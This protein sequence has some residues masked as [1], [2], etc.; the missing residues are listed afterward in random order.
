MKKNLLT[1]LLLGFFAFSGAFAQ[2][3]KTT[4]KVIG[5]DDGLPLPGVTVKVKGTQTGVQTDGDGKFSIDA[6]VGAQLVFSYIGFTEQTIAVPAG[7][8]PVVKLVTNTRLLSEVVVTDGY[9][10]QARKSYT[11]SATTISGAANENKPFSSPMQALQG[12]VA[13]LNVQTNSGQPGANVQVRLR[14]VNSISAGANPLYVIDNMIVNSGDLSRLTVTTNVLAGINENDIESITVL[15]DAAATAIYG[16]RGG[17][18]VIV[19]TTKKGKAGKTQIRVDAE[20][21]ATSNLNPPTAGRLLTADE[22]KTLFTEGENNAAVDFP[23]TFTPTRVASDI[24]SYIGTTSNDWYKLIT[25]TGTQQQYN[26]SM[27]GGSDATRVFGS[28]GYFKQEA[29]TIASSLKRITG[30]FNVDHNISKRFTISTNINFSNVNQFTPSNGGAFANPVGSIY[31]LTPF[32]LAYNPD[33]TLNSSRA[34][35]TNFPSQFN[36]LYLAKNDKKYDSQTRILTGAT[37]KWNIWD[38]LKFTSF[39]SID[40]NVLEEQQFNNPIMGDGRTSNGRGYDYYTRYFNWL[41]RNSLD[42]RYDIPGI[43]NFYVSA[44]VGYEAQ[45]SQ[46]YFISANS[47]GY[48]ATQPLLT[49]SANA[50]T[51][52]L[53]NSSF[54]NYAVDALYSVAS[55]NYKNR[56][57]LSGSFR[58][59]GSSVFGATNKYGNFASIGGAWNIDQ[60]KFFAVQKVLSSAK[61]RSSF[62]TTGNLSGVG[63]YSAQP[64]AGYGVNY[65]G[66]NGQNYSTVGNPDLA[67]E[68]QKKFDV[69]MD[70]GFFND[71]LTFGVEYYHNLVDKLIQ[72]AP[73]SRTTGFSSI[74]ENIGAMLNRGVEGTVKGYPVKSK[75][76]TWFTSFNI[77]ANKNTVQSLLNHAPVAS[78]VFQFREG[79]DLYTYFVRESAGVD[80]ANGNALWYT[81]GTKTA[82]T[83]SY[84]AATRVNKYQADP[85]LFGGFNNTFTYKG[86]SLSA[87][88]YYNFGNY[89]SDPSWGFYLNDGTS[90]NNNKYYYIY[91]N[92]W[93][94]PGQVTDVPKYSNA[95]VNAGSSSSF[96]TRLMYYGDYIRLKNLQ[97]GYDFK[98]IEFLK[99]MGIT[100][101]HLYGRGTNLWT[102]TYD[103][104]LPFDPEQGVTG[105]ANLEVMQAK[106]FTVGLNVGF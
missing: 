40:Y 49:A 46:A 101:L 19:I 88:F 47:N 59:D 17:N 21:G 44:T 86:I 90:F 63:V 6:T 91:A 80:P 68:S 70:F 52:I 103:K 54:S 53:G 28:A 43:D 22:F 29:T 95:G 39:G 45:R 73:I 98:D 42:Y 34:G 7:T 12:E 30:Q 57:S 69:G 78:S 65:A 50:A 1:I 26:V 58:R 32:Q 67:W 96:S 16:S 56:Y 81:D 8:F 25:R 76:F 20:A 11:G 84:A 82:T 24:A 2:S 55:I 61:L 87:D 37:I 15:K 97:I 31:F 36:P 79:M 74:T 51:P 75:D 33:G 85:K 100:K 89:V 83:S 72:A 99:K 66:N 4:G 94:T 48:P 93:T 77:A 71:R 62:G 3:R 35:N 41:T 102:K 9:V 27:N 104:R 38:Q 106:T 10:T 5:S 64:T 60:E 105:A 13:G 14:G 18:G 23:G 92:R